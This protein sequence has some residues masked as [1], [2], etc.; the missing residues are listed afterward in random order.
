M[1]LLMSLPMS[2]LV[3]LKE[4]LR[5]NYLIYSVITR[6]Q[7]YSVEKKISILLLYSFISKE[8]SEGACLLKNLSTVSMLFGTNLLI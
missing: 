2:T 3:K 4:I 8:N 1:T 7:R 6:E 5:Y